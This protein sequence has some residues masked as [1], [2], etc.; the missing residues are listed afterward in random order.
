[1]EF[2][3]TYKHGV[4]PPLPFFYRQPIAV[5]DGDVIHYLSQQGVEIRRPNKIFSFAGF[6]SAQVLEFINRTGI[7]FIDPDTP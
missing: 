3:G 1:M 5:T 4:T 7:V 6:S 2:S